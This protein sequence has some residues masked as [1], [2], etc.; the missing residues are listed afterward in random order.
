MVCYSKENHHDLDKELQSIERI[1][2]RALTKAQ[3]PTNRDTRV[4]AVWLG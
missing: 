2:R 1:E 4:P 3:L